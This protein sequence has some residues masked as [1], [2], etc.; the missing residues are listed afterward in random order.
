MRAVASVPASD[1]FALMMNP[2]VVLA[3]MQGSDRLGDLK[4]RV[5]RPLDKPLIPKRSAEMQA[6]D[7]ALDALESGKAASDI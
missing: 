7:D 3:A 2:A 1:P 4:R 6:F 5:C